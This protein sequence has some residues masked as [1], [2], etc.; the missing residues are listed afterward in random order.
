MS[1]DDFLDGHDQISVQTPLNAVGYGD[2]DKDTL[3]DYNDDLTMSRQDNET[4]SVSSDNT[5]AGRN[6]DRS[7]PMGLLGNNAEQG[8]DIGSDEVWHEQ[9]QIMWENREKMEHLKKCLQHQREMAENKLQ[10]EQERAEVARMESEIR[11]LNQ[12]RFDVKHDIPVVSNVKRLTQK[13][14]SQTVKFKS[15]NNSKVSHT[16]VNTGQREV[17]NTSQRKPKAKATQAKHDKLGKQRGDKYTE[18]QRRTALEEQHRI[19]QWLRESVSS[20]APENIP[21][22]Q[23]ESG[24]GNCDES[25]FKPQLLCCRWA[26]REQRKAMEETDISGDTTEGTTRAPLSAGKRPVPVPTHNPPM[27]KVVRAE[28]Q[29]MHRMEDRDSDGESRVSVISS[30][31]H[32]SR[33]LSSVVGREV[34]CKDTVETK[35]PCDLKSGFLDKPRSTVLVK[36]KWPHMNQNPRYVTEALTFNQLMF[37]SSLGANVIRFEGPRTRRSWQADSESC[38]RCPIC[39]SSV[40][41]GTGLGLPILQLSAALRRVSHHGQVHLDTTT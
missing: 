24:F 10:E 22:L 25:V 21:G 6:C 36:H 4:I 2:Q 5:T 13:T 41:T 26:M 31:S 15:D 16:P 29:T 39:W 20:I 3:L 14:G 34:K 11:L 17:L 38:P 1:D 35:I 9:E 8:R 30:S 27:R 18:I 7:R 37:P 40:G 32:V 12:K 23:A 28:P 33:A 19:E